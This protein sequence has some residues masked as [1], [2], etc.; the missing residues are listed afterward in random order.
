MLNDTIHLRN[1]RIVIHYDTIQQK[2]RIEQVRPV[3]VVKDSVV[4]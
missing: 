1:E 2:L 4:R 3:V